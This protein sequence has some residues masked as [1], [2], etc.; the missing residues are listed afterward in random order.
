M[1][2]IKST[3]PLSRVDAAT[4]S[5]SKHASI[6]SREAARHTRSVIY[7]LRAVKIKM[8]CI[9]SVTVDSK[10]DKMSRARARSEIFCTFFLF[11]PLFCQRNQ[12]Q[13]RVPD[14]LFRRSFLVLFAAAFVSS[15]VVSLVNSPVPSKLI[16]ALSDR[17]A[18]IY[19][20][21]MRARSHD[22]SPKSYGAGA[23]TRCE[24]HSG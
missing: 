11:S 10:H 23:A 1:N 20:A 13:F 22:K 8:V 14:A 12:V 6:K 16:I 2:F 5:L 24:T 18:W 4:D 19:Y 7:L 3:L 9:E 21:R 17:A 15:T